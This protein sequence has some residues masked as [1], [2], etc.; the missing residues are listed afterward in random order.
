[1]STTV[2][3]PVAVTSLIVSVLT[4]I[5]A[6]FT[7]CKRCRCCGSDIEFKTSAPSSATDLESKESKE[8]DGTS[9]GHDD[10][11]STGTKMSTLMT[12][13]ESNVE[14]T[15]IRVLEEQNQNHGLQL[16]RQH[17]S[18]NDRSPTRSDRSPTRIEPPSEQLQSTDRNSIGN[19]SPAS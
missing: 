5:G 11:D 17:A 1:M 3:D 15:I 2:W 6:I 9:E 19:R 13:V 8:S 4:A 16:E 10:S 18:S 7:R 14:N 12:K